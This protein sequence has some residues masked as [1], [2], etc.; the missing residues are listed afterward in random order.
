MQYLSWTIG[1]IS[2]ILPSSVAG[3]RMGCEEVSQVTSNKHLLD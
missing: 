2:I 1:G 3:L